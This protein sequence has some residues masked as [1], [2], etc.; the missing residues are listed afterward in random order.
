MFASQCIVLAAC[1]ASVL[2]HTH[3]VLAGVHGGF[4]EPPTLCAQKGDIV[5]FVFG[6]F[7]NGSHTATQSSFANP[8]LP[9]PG[10]FSS[11]EAQLP[12]GAS[13]DDAPVWNLSITDTSQPIWFFCEVSQPHSHCADGMVGVINPP[14][15][16][17]FTTFLAAA[18]AVSGTPTPT[19]SVALTGIGAVATAPPAP[20]D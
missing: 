7:G 15:P 5:Q 8:C 17:S 2:S 1:V 13:L 20:T 4:Y 11:G 12:I 9:L 6:N 16:A 3:T 10:G 19:I 14:S 18:K